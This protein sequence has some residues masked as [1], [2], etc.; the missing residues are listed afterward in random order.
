M[1]K[2]SHLLPVSAGFSCCD[3][4]AQ[5]KM[6]S[7]SLELAQ[8][9]LARMRRKSYHI[10]RRLTRLSQRV[11]NSRA[12][13]P[14][15]LLL[16]VI[17]MAL[18]LPLAGV[19]TMTCITI[20]LLLTCPDLLAPVC[21]FMMTFLLSTQ[22]YEELGRLLP[23]AVL[24]PPLLLALL[25]HLALWP[26]TLRVGRS[27][28][29]LLLVS[30]A[31]LLGGCDVLTRRQ[32]LSPLSLY[33]SLGLGAGMLLL[34]ILFRSH[35]AQR[36]SYD[37]QRRF[38][39]LLYTLGLCMAA[40]VLLAYVRAL[41]AGQ[42]DGRLLYLPYRNFATSV[43]LTTLPMPFYLSLRHRT[44]LIGA[45]VMAA[46]LVLSGSRSALLFGGVCLLLCF[47]YLLRCGA[48]SRRQLACLAAA[49]GLCLLAMG[50]PLLELVL[51]SRSGAQ[52]QDSNSDRLQFLARAVDDFLRHPLFGVGLGSRRNADVFAGVDGSMVFY[53]NSIAQIMGS[54]GL[55][56]I[57]AYG[58][59]FYDRVRLLR[60]RP[61]P[62]T[63]VL[64][65]SYLGMLLI[66]LCNP[67]SFCPFPNAALL[68]MLFAQAEEATGDVAVP[69]GQLL[70]RRS[71]IPAGFLPF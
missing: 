64:A 56:G 62:F 35:L 70:R 54:M 15:L 55:V 17:F 45:A 19:S 13:F 36:R 10:F 26:V 11:W 63:Q 51:G 50:Q 61:T 28:V 14:A 33:Y 5:S 30:A 20:W 39:H 41:C 38:A 57:L 8:G 37:L 44:H 4:G 24:V 7:P 2:V 29:G 3:E 1:K 69:L 67:G 49:A 53:H 32:A 48:L 6:R 23:C 42:L 9:L 40:A 27:A 12:F 68:V 25:W 59:L 22:C 60:A 66:S 65:L 43:L 18:E 16:A 71:R 52:L 31:T 47:W 21:P 34:Y 58:R 46:A